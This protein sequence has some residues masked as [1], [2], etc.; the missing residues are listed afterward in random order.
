[1]NDTDNPTSMPSVLPVS[2]EAARL[3]GV[4]YQWLGVLVLAVAVGASVGGWL[5]WDYPVDVSVATTLI[6]LAPVF[7]GALLAGAVPLVCALRAR[8]RWHAAI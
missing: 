2:A 7:A 4:Y 3:R 8:R 1:M 5:G 6:G